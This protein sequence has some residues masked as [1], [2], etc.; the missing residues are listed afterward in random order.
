MP[1]TVLNLLHVLSPRPA[2]SPP[3]KS[4]W[5]AVIIQLW[6]G[7]VDTEQDGPL[8]P[9]CWRIQ[10]WQLPG[11]WSSGISVLESATNIARASW[12]AGKAGLSGGGQ[13]VPGQKG[14]RTMRSLASNPQTR[15]SNTTSSFFQARD[16]EPRA[17][18]TRRVPSRTTH[19]ISAGQAGTCVFFSGFVISLFLPL[20]PGKLN[21]Y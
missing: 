20:D 2:N 19:P 5:P 14:R 15:G 6:D 18:K 10:C 4:H 17:L 21:Y 7:T 9:T 3:V 16:Q 13:G 8:Y 12:Q 1:D 11:T